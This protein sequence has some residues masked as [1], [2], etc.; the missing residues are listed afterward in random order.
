MVRILKL[1]FFLIL[2]AVI[3]V[4]GF[5][6]FGDLRPDRTEVNQPIELNVD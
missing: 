5:A 2:I 3:A 6:Y 1:L 4:I